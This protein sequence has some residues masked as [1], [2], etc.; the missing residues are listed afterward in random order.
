MSANAE[1]RQKGQRIDF[2]ADGA[3]SRHDCLMP[4]TRKRQPLLGEAERRRGSVSSERSR[5]GLLCV[6]SRVDLGFDLRSHGGH[7]RISCILGRRRAIALKS[8]MSGK[9]SH[10]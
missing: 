9:S 8:M 7:C 3:E 4:G 1:L 6:S 2:V 5:A 10:G